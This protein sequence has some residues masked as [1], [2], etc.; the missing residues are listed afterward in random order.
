MTL[1]T[2]LFSLTQLITHYA[3][4]ICLMMF[5]L[6]SILVCLQVRPRSEEFDLAVKFVTIGSNRFVV[7][8]VVL[9][10]LVITR[11]RK[12]VIPSM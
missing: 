5:S 12:H 11:S 7:S 1:S 10:D 3:N 9:I 2:M 8:S 6:R 4:G